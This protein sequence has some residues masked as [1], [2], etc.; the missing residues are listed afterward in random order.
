[1]LSGYNLFMTPQIPPELRQAIDEREGKPVYVVDAERQKTYV[2]LSAE[3]Y[4]RIRGLFG[5]DDMTPDDFL[6]ATAAAL[7]DVLHAP[8]MEKYDD[9]DAH[10]PQR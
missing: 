7:R 3:L 4:D 2:L 8:G 1:M 10:R 5:D 9:Y 6:P